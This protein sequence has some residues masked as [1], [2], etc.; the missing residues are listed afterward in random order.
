MP[1]TFVYDVPTNTITVTDGTSG[2]PA[3]FHDMFLADG[4][5]GWG[6]VD[7]V[8]AD[9]M[10]KIDCN[11]Y[12]GDGGT[13][14]HFTSL[15]EL[16][17]FADDMLLQ[18]ENLATLQMGE[19]TTSYGKNGSAFKFTHPTS[20]M[21]ITPVGQATAAVEMYA[22][23]I[24]WEDD[25]NYK[26]LIFAAGNIK[27]YG[28]NFVMSPYSDL[29][30]SGLTSLEAERV[31]VYSGAS[32]YKFEYIAGGTFNDCLA[33]AAMTGINFNN[34]TITVTNPI[35]TNPIA[36]S[37]AQASAHT[38]T[39]Q[40]PS[41]SAAVV[42]IQAA[43][44]VLI[45][46]Y[47]CNIHVTDKDGADL[48]SVDVDCEYAH[49]VEGSDSKTYKCIQDHTSVD[50]VHKPI[51]GSD[52]ASFWE[53]YDASGGLG[54]PWQTTFDFKAGDE[55]FSTATT[56]VDGDISEQVIQYKKWV[57]TSELLEARI[58]KFTFSHASYPDS[59]MNDVIVDHLLVWE[60]GM[61]QSTS[62]LTTIVQG[63]IETN[64]L[65]HLVAV[66]AAEDE[67]IDNTVVARLAATEG[68]WSEFNDENHSLEALRVRGDAAW[69]T[70]TSVIV[71]DKTGFSLSTAG[72]LAIWHQLVAAVVTASTMG[73]LIVDYLNAAIGTRAPANEYDTEMA[74]ID[75]S[76]SATQ[77]NIIMEIDINEV[78]IDAIPTADAIITAL[79]AD[80][81]FTAG[82]TMT[83]EKYL[84]ISAAW[85]AGN[86]R[87]KSGSA[88]VR[89]LLD[90]D[91]GSTVIL[92]MKISKTT[93]Y[94]TVTIMI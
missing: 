77:S 87:S 83:Y 31:S 32:G 56:D 74:R 90:V 45:E 61:G 73:K 42:T 20:T 39:I 81:G 51:T 54:G 43:N 50:T 37:Y 49:L 15:K 16:V 40:N 7:E 62:D 72:I 60:M 10:Y 69:P 92:E 41:E 65:D 18:V 44:G 8:A 5:G 26:S 46:Q 33:D 85:H 89:E 48:Q 58:Y 17:L 36:R 71:S 35:I 67:V 1:G 78:K 93:P 70:A 19:A 88:D 80:T 4:V 86:W 28:V 34:A 57:G 3:T 14:T 82:G 94:R 29:R 91:D 53:L 75:Q 52:W 47:T 25:N 21:L 30:L 22:S 11:V 79:M 63:V 68:D 55:E 76:L 38:S 66:A 2:A 13:S 64:K 24:I 59:V 9:E 23:T 27:L 12:I 84:K 6:V